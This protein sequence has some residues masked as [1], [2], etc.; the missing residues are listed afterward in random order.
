MVDA[1]SARFAELRFLNS[2]QVSLSGGS[3]RP[4]FH[5]PCQRLAND[6]LARNDPR[7]A[8]GRLGES[9]VYV[10]A[11]SL[12]ACFGHW[13]AWQATRVEVAQHHELNRQRREP[14]K[15]KVVEIVQETTAELA[16]DSDKQTTGSVDLK[17]GRPGRAASNREAP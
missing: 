15:E 11:L 17:E 13:S 8:R 9:V 6:V 5:A 3:G 16:L 10:S 1:F 4:R 12:W 2:Y 7:L 14:L